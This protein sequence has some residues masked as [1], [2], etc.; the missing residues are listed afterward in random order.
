[1]P[2]PIN[3]LVTLKEFGIVGRLAFFFYRSVEG[4][5]FHVQKYLEKEMVRWNGSVLSLL[6]FVLHGPIVMRRTETVLAL[7]FGQ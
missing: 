3:M 7:D 5:A 6:S 2:K 4:N 1:M